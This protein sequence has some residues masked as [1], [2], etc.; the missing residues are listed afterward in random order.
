ML[1][2]FKEFRVQLP[3][4]DIRQLIQYNSSLHFVEIPL[5]DKWTST[6]VWRLCNKK[7]FP[8]DWHL[9]QQPSCKGIT[10]LTKIGIQMSTLPRRGGHYSGGL[11]TTV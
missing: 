6:V 9:N 4:I 8:W 1:N 5:N 7:S 11:Q 2:L 3:L 10:F